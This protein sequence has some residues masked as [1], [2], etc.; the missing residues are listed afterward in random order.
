MI[1]DFALLTYVLN[2][3]QLDKCGV[4]S[5]KKPLKKQIPT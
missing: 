3:D 5:G 4:F 1:V 2:F